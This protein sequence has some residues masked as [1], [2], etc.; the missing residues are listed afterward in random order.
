MVDFHISKSMKFSHQEKIVRISYQFKFHKLILTPFLAL[1]GTMF[2]LNG[3]LN[4]V[5]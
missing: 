5:M 2:Y 3:N 1:N 4:H